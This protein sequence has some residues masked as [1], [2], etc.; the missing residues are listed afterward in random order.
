MTESEAMDVEFDDVAR[1]TLDAVRR[2]GPDHAVA[3]ACRGSASPAA[4]DWLAEECGLGAG[5]VLLDVGGGMGGPAAHAAATWRV[6]PVVAEPMHGACVAAAR[7]FP[8]LAVVR[9]AGESL[10]L[11]TASVPAVWCLGVLCTMADQA[12]LLAE[13][14]RV[15]APGGALGL[16]VL[17][18][19][20]EEL[21]EVPEGNHFPTAADLDRLLADAGFTTV[22]RI[23]AADLPDTPQAWQERI[24]RVERVIDELHADDPRQDVVQDQEAIMA[25]LLGSGAVTTRLLV[26]RVPGA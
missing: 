2:L 25:R 19:E 15:L 26:A 1:W 4:L 14:H 12:G 22:A 24:E 21:P 11:R 16:L 10:P 5:E 9:S 20:S 7:L 6:R 23:A 18:A 8:G 3:A 13:L 17:V